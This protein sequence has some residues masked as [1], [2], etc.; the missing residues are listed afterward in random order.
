MKHSEKKKRPQKTYDLF[1][2]QEQ[3]MVVVFTD[4]SCVENG[5]EAAEGGIGVFFPFGEFHNIATFYDPESWGPGPATNQ[6]CEIGAVIVA[7]ERLRGDPRPVRIYTDSIYVANMWTKWFPVWRETHDT[8]V[9]RKNLALVARLM[10][11]LAEKDV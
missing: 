1:V 6:K 9:D 10:E 5:T 2:Q 8:I 7:L 4:G 11:L 3:G